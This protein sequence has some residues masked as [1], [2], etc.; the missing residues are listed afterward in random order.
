M[1]AFSIF[2]VLVSTSSENN[3]SCN[4][5]NTSQAASGNKMCVFRK[6]LL[7]V[8]ERLINTSVR[9]LLSFVFPLSQPAPELILS[10]ECKRKVNLFMLSG[11]LLDRVAEHVGSC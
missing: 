9:T 8:T 10:R 5:V 6:P 1:I 3:S 2:S 11:V 7:F 4:A